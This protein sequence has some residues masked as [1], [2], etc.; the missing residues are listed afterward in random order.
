M[1][2]EHILYKLWLKKTAAD[3]QAQKDLKGIAGNE[4]E[5]GDRFYRE[6]SFGTAGL[7]GIMGMGINRMN[8]YTVGRATQGF[9]KY[10]HSKKTENPSVAIAY[11]SRLN[12][13]EFARYAA[14]V[15]AAN[16]VK[17]LIYKELMPTPA[18]SYAIRELGCDGGINI[19]ASHNPAAYNGYKA[20]D[21]SGCQIGPEI[22]DV[23]QKSIL[24]TDL[25]SGVET[26]DF[27]AA[28]EKGLVEFIPQSFVERYLDRV[29]AEA[30]Q[31]E[32][33][34][35]AGL[36]LIY[37]PLNGAG[38]NCVS[39]IFAR[40]G[41]KDVHNVPEQVAP[42]GNFPTCPYP[43]P[44]IKEALSLGLKLAAEKKADILI[45][46][47][48]DADRVG[49][50]VP[51]GEGGYRIFTGNEVGILLLDYI[52][53]TRKKL[54]KMPDKPVAVRSL[55]SSRMADAV[56]AHYGVE[57][58]KVLTGFRFIGGVIAGLEET[59]RADSFIFGFE[60]SCGYLTGGFVRDKD[61]VN[62]VLMLTEMAAAYKL[63]GKT[64]VDALEELYTQFGVWSSEVDNFAYEGE[65]GMKAMAGIMEGLRKQPPVEI[66]GDAVGETL[67]YKQGARYAGDGWSPVDLPKTDMVEL[68]L[69]NGNSIII[70]P[71]GTEPK[72]KIYYVVTGKGHQSV[73]QKNRDYRAACAKIVGR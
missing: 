11:D 20:Y 3:A 27:D 64:L 15:L 39:A 35:E 24:E 13:K 68:K 17:A 37:T 23:V 58:V 12:S 60:E 29:C 6:L 63:A 32:I 45:A 1:T 48:P 51:D 43:N 62:A 7:R 19:T 34:K 33:C 31:P 42:D 44:E 56:A 50:A 46:T 16:G 53:K 2:N 4:A 8:R 25:F 47:D 18:L 52:C 57:M 69:K 55:V 10:L 21:A 49:A 41:I 5:I 65:S 72:I 70:R 71:S 67:D 14:G 40:L 22:A 9:A 54:G 36:K 61:A 38:M 28:L 26:M 66:A 30:L 73:A 59:G